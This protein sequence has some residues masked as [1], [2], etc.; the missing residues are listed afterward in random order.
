MSAA[1]ALTKLVDEC[2]LALTRRLAAT[3]EQ[4]RVVVAEVLGAE[5]VRMNGMPGV[6]RA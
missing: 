2:H 6:S 4:D 1:V 5:D 3:D